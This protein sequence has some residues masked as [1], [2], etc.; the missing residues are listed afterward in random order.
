MTALIRPPEWVEDAACA[1]VDA[2]LWYPEKGAVS[3]E[4]KRICKT[5]CRVR[6]QCETWALDNHEQ[7]GIW[8]GLSTPER[9]R[10]RKQ[11]EATQ[12]EAA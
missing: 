2:D 5:R 1:R 7:Y 8:G 6:E 11:R 9:Q 10:L 12:Q 3:P 4:A